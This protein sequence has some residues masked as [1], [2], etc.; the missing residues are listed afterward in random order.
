MYLTI[1]PAYG[2]D[3]TSQK[4]VREDWNANK[5]FIIQDISSPDNGRAINKSDAEQ[6][7]PGITVNIR[8]KKFTQVLPIKLK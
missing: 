8:Y 6:F 4:A 2:R 1:V 3:Y 5:D 7:S